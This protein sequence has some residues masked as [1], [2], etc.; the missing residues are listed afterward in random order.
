MRI[1]TKDLILSKAKIE[2]L[3]S[4][5]NNYWSQEE[6]AKFMLWTVCKS[7]EEARER[8]EKVIEFQKDKAAY[9]VYEKASGNA[10]GMAA[11]IEISPK[12]FEDGGI[13]IG[14]K[15][16][17]RGY[18][19]QILNALINYTFNKLDAEKIICSCHTD[20]IPSAR[21]QK[22]CGMKYV[23]SKNETRKKDNLTYKADYYEITKDEYL[24]QIK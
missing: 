15:Y 19:K 7:L 4:I 24:N 21:L 20:N 16:I 23:Y 2:D 12:V 5:Y 13:G 17:G 22:S 18:G 3:E 10:I 14:K 6:T 9:F 1:E 11:M 8:L